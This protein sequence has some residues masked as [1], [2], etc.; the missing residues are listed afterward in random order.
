MTAD[1]IAAH[2]HTGKRDPQPD[3]CHRQ[4]LEIV[5]RM[6]REQVAMDIGETTTAQP[7]TLPRTGVYV[8]A[9]RTDDRPCNTKA[10]EAP[11]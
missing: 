10:A 1:Q 7:R 9:D 2:R 6:Q 8:T 11:R 5:N 3:V 4:V